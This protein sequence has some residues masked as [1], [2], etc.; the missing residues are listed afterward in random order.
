MAFAPRGEFDLADGDPAFGRGAG[1]YG[2]ANHAAAKRGVKR[3]AGQPLERR[4]NL[5]P[6]RARCDAR[7][8]LQRR[9]QLWPEFRLAGQTQLQC[10]GRDG[11]FGIPTGGRA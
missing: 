3:K 9:I 7:S 11:L 2:R 6:A 5:C 4:S 8:S 10:F 1:R